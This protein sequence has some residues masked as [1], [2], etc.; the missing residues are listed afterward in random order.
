VLRITI[1]GI[2]VSSTRHALAAR[3]LALWTWSGRAV[4]ERCAPAALGAPLFRGR[5]EREVATSAFE[6]KRKSAL[7]S[8]CESGSRGCHIRGKAARRGLTPWAGCP[9]VRTRPPGALRSVCRVLVRKVRKV[10]EDSSAACQ[11]HPGLEGASDRAVGFAR[12]QR[13]HGA[14]QRGAARAFQLGRHGAK[15]SR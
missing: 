12:G 15:L 10:V 5:R 13:R 3:S 8:W 11:G 14:L 6:P 7:P 4:S 1:F 9:I 2:F